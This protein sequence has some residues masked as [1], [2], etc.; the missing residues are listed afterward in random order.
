MFNTVNPFAPLT[1]LKFNASP[2][3]TFKVFQ[4]TVESPL[5]F[6]VAE[7]VPVCIPAKPPDV[8]LITAPPF[9]T[10]NPVSIAADT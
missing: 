3:L 7:F 1:A 9:P 10:P 6:K 2:L 4:F 5:K 8:L